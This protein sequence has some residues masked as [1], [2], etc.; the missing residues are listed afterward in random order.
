MTGRRRK[1]RKGVVVARARTTA[2]I[3]NNQ[4]PPAT[5]TAARTTGGTTRMRIRKSRRRT[6]KARIMQSQDDDPQDVDD[7]QEPK[8]KTRT[9]QAEE[10]NNKTSQ[11]NQRNNNNNHTNNVNN[12]NLMKQTRA[13]SSQHS[14]ASCS[15]GLRKPSS[16]NILAR[17]CSHVV[18]D[19][20][21]IFPRIKS[22]MRATTAT[23]KQGGKQLQKHRTTA[24]V[25]TTGKHTQ[26]K[27]EQHWRTIGKPQDINSVIIRISVFIEK[28]E[29]FG[30]FLLCSYCSLHVPYRCFNAGECEH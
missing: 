30:G 5:T 2:S 4:N 24:A 28:F 15:C 16:R 25:P 1:R 23:L 14:L 19:F 29:M 27:W 20:V 9:K 18:Q 11:Y 7:E 22:E 21:S 10:S 6:G 13:M 26:T 12:H 3:S 8:M 17:S